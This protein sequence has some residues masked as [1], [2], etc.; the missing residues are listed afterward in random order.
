[1]LRDRLGGKKGVFLREH[2]NRGN[3]PGFLDPAP[4]LVFLHLVTSSALVR[5]SKFEIRK[6]KSEI[7]K[8]A[9]VFDFAAP[10][11]DFR[12]SIFGFTELPP[13]PPPDSIEPRRSDKH[14]SESNSLPERSDSRSRRSGNPA[15]ML[16]RADKNRSR[17]HARGL[18]VRD[19]S[20]YRAA[21]GLCC[22]PR[23]RKRYPHR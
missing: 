1:A 10:I 17:C 21:A 3:N 12:V 14:R 15:R 7:R 2:A 19:I 20:P 13:G 23:W 9:R 11:L 4:H 16:R 22:S 8:S 18:P 6:S 5:K